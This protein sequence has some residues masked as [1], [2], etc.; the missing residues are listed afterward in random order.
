MII[1]QQKMWRWAAT[2]ALT[3]SALSVTQIGIAQDAKTKLTGKTIGTDGSYQD[4]GADKTKAFD[5]DTATFFDAPEATNGNGVWVGLDLG[6][7]KDATIAKIRFYPRTDFPARMVNGKFQG[8]DTADFSK[9]VVD[10]FTVDTEPT[11]DQWTETTKIGSDKKFRYVRYLA[12]DDGWGNVSEI[13]L[14]TK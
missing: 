4:G 11:A 9:N 10:L 2:C 7:G 14:F 12:P 3:L 5:G 13:E 8:S 6:E 1:K